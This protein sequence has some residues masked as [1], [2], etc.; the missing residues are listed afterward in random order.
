MNVGK[1]TS[2]AQSL[3]DIVVQQYRDIKSRLA[4]KSNFE[5]SKV[6]VELTSDCPN[7]EPNRN[8]EICRNVVE[9]QV[10]LRFSETL[11]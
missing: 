2:N 4:I 7:R 1:L 10:S 6:S 5:K 9:N 11:K 3:E 8:L